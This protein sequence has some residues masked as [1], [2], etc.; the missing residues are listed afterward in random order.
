MSVRTGPIADDLKKVRNVKPLWSKFGLLASL[1][2]GGLDMWTNSILGLSVFG[3]LRHGKTDAAATGLAKD[4]KP[5]S[6]PKP[7][8]V[9][10][11]DRLTN[12]AFSATNHQEGQPSH[13]TLRD[14][15]VPIRINLPL[16]A[17]PAQRYCPAGVYE[18]VA[19]PG[20][21]ARFV[22][23]FQNCVHC[24]TCDI[25]DPSQNIHWKTPQGG[26]GPNYPNM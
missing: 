6:Y 12:I 23:N 8:G 22:I 16:Y 13:L 9:L 1:M 2:G 7:D 14:A 5:I 24:K 11:F 4:H 25:K 17:E 21:D 10:S 26:D 15:S 3:T 19:E 18:V 20:K